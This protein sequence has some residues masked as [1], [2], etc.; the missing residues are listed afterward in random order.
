M[1]TTTEKIQ[2]KIRYSTIALVITLSTIITIVA[3]YPYY[4]KLR[5]A[6]KNNLIFAR[7]TSALIINEYLSRIKLY[8][9][10]ISIASNAPKTTRKRTSMLENYPNMVGIIKL[11][12]NGSIVSKRGKA[13]PKAYWPDTEGDDDIIL[14][15]P[16]S[17][18]NHHFIAIA[19]PVFDKQL[20]RKGVDLVLFDITSIQANMYKKMPIHLGS[21]IIANKK[22]GEL[23]LFASNHSKWSNTK[24]SD[25]FL[26]TQL[27]NTIT[28][29]TPN[30]AVGHFM[31]REVY[32]A[33]MPLK[34]KNWAL[35]IIINKSQLLSKLDNTTY[36]IVAINLILII[37][38]IFAL[39]ALLKP[40][41]GRI[42]MRN[43]ELEKKIQNSLSQ[44]KKAN[45]KLKAL[46]SQDPLT[47]CYNRR[48][49]NQE[50]SKILS[51]A[52]RNTTPFSL[53]FIDVNKFKIINDTYG[54][55]AGDFLL[56]SL[57]E[58]LAMGMR[59]EDIVSRI[60]GDEF[61]VIAPGIDDLS[62]KNISNKIQQIASIPIVFENHSLEFNVSIGIACYPVHG[63]SIEQLLSFADDLM[64]E[65]KR[66]P[67]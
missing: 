59:K 47:G 53:I 39:N 6:E 57:A 32:A 62:A 12:N 36:T 23:Q 48:G 7:N 37:L 67:T 60:G 16:Y 52:K 54:H 21:T 18:H 38:F 5:Q 26:K 31:G 22:N 45:L 58:R 10:Q 33:F 17:I 14:S 61:V 4:S 44:L 40:L 28:N 43:R 9:Q 24:N 8:A 2:F 50:F 55:D 66:R 1:H 20:N 15:P 19:C 34:E 56:I 13:I 46:A 42:I 30:T 63:D 49:F 29:Q 25:T 27:L 35:A 11:D 51:S 65:H 3:I 41:S 64:Y